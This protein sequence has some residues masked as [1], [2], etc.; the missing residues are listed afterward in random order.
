MTSCL[1]HFVAIN[2][3]IGACTGDDRLV[4]RRLDNCSVTVVDVVDGQLTLI[5]WGRSRHPHP[6]VPC[7]A[8]SE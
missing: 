8:R 4:I 7:H 2:A 6:L 1:S 5:E 3:V